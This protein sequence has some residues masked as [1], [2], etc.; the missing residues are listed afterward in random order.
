M[1]RKLDNILVID[2]EA[3]CWQGDPPRGQSSEIIEVG[4]CL[5][6]VAGLARVERRS[7]LVRPARRSAL[8]ART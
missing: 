2:V 5:L 6:D 3:T 8:S 4:L 7:I 1:A